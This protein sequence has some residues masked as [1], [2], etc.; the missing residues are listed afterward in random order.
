MFFTKEEL[1]LKIATY[2]ELLIS[3][4]NEGYAAFL[5]SSFYPKQIIDTVTLVLN[6]K[7][8]AIFLNTI[9]FIDHEIR[10]FYPRAVE[11]LPLIIKFSENW[12]IYLLWNLDRSID[13][14]YYYAWLRRWVQ[15]PSHKDIGLL[16]LLFGGVSAV[17]GV[18]FSEYIRIE[19]AFPGTG[20]FS[21]NWHLYNVAI[22]AHA[23]LM[24]FFTVMPILIGGFGNFFVP[25]LLGAPDMAYPRLN[26]ISFWLLV[27]SLVLLL[28]SALVEAGAGT[29]WTV[30]PPLSGSQAHSG[31]A[32]DL[33]IFSLH[34]SGISSIAGAINFIVTIHNMRAP[35]MHYF[36]MPLF[37]WSM[38]V[39][40]F[41]L[42]TAL[43]VL[44]GGLTMLLTDRN[45]NTSFFDPAGGGDP[46]LFQ[47]LFWFFGH[48]EVYI[49]ILPA[50]GIVSHV[51]AHFARKPVFGYL[52]MVYAMGSIGFLGFIVWAHHMFQVG[53]D[54]D[55]RAYF[56]AATMIIAI[57][58]GIKMFSW[59]A[60]LWGGSIRF[61]APMMFALGFLFL[62][63][64]GGLTGLVLSNSGVNAI[65]HDTYYVVAHFHYV[66]SM[67]ALFAI[68][69]AWYYWFN[70]LFGLPYNNYFAYL[71]F[72]TFF[73][74]VNLTFF[75][76]HFLGLAGMPRRIPDYP[77]AFASYNFIATIGSFISVVSV[78]F[79]VT[80]VFLSF[81][82]PYASLWDEMVNYYETQIINTNFLM[83]LSLPMFRQW[84]SFAYYP[85]CN[86]DETLKSYIKYWKTLHARHREE[87]RKQRIERNEKLYIYFTENFLEDCK[88]LVVYFYQLI[89]YYL[90]KFFK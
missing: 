44:A 9:K 84:F 36:R 38:L 25:I 37:V 6:S 49:M 86:G 80:G 82:Y 19:L 23:L 56:T 59:M 68:F 50:F 51:I 40:A 22:T 18:T 16:Y 12:Y 62:F 81:T 85:E 4:V 54:V 28:L 74:G 7:E 43:P 63:T 48:P 35:G 2:R 58:T 46:I 52:G 1:S 32:V 79:F 70:D 89:V 65:L 60:T 76:M 13:T 83:P 24:I 72:Y 57:P 10:T 66:L 33:A 73:L 67:G 61:T 21:G 42:V 87:V 29:G 31:P 30:Y 14:A 71:H 11:A 8:F 77:D 64:M 69:V 53:L 47:H 88:K 26:N 45:F 17:L 5:K 55:T 75:P 90:Y 20:I 34:L 39:T 41:L 27:P 3:K 15:S 78:L